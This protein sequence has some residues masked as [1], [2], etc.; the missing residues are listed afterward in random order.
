MFY[1]NCMRRFDLFKTLSLLVAL[2]CLTAC[3]SASKVNLKNS[4]TEQDLFH[5]DVMGAPAQLPSLPEVFELTAAQKDH[6]L[7]NYHNFKYRDLS[8]SQRIYEFLKDQLSSFN[9]HSDTLVATDAMAQNAGNCLSLAILT[10]ALAQLTNVG[11][12][13]ELARTPPVFQ[14]EGDLLLSSQ[15]IRAVV[16]DKNS[17]N[18]KQFIRPNH[19]IKIDYFSTVGSR[20]LRRVNKEEFYAMFYSN[21]AAEAM[22][23][24]AYQ[25]AYWH[26]K[27]ALRHDNDNVIAINILGVIYRR[28][29]FM[30]Y[31]ERTFQYG[32]ASGENQL[33][34]LNNYHKLLLQQNRT[35]DAAVIAKKLEDYDDPDP[36]KW[37]DLAEAELREG[38]YHKAIKLFNQAAEKASYLHQPYAGIARANFHLGRTDRAVRAI[39]LAIENSH[40]NDTTALYQAKHDYFKSL[41]NTN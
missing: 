35:A 8:D 31:A 13:Y 7:K 22:V 16:Y 10:K 11:V 20:M 21:R 24:G 32:I 29:G 39:Q 17:R 19:K 37:I 12:S 14:R 1:N 5:D 23:E 25:K 38:N 26:L 34:L 33:E 4:Y 3:G 36:F 2:G 15:H 27:E 28:M 6:F 41:E 9:F 18:T 30:D 40:R